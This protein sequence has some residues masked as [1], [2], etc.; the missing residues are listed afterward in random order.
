MQRC[1]TCHPLNPAAVQCSTCETCGQIIYA[2]DAGL[3]C[4]RHK[5]VYQ[6]QTAH[7]NGQIPVRVETRP[8]PPLVTEPRDLQTL[9]IAELGAELTALRDTP[10]AGWAPS[11][12]ERDSALQELARRQA[13]EARARRGRRK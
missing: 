12:P 9:T 2:W 1:R 7:R 5:N 4:E 6:W 3:P 11:S 8:G 10:V 13:A